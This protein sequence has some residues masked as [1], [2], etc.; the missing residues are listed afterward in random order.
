MFSNQVNV[1]GKFISGTIQ[2]KEAHHAY[3]F[4]SQLNLG[5]RGANTWNSNTLREIANELNDVANELD[6]QNI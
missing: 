3:L 2:R 6:K 1:N 5:G 4:L